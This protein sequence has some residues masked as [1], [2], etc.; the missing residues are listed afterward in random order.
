MHFRLSLESD[1]SV[2]MKIINQAQTQLRDA[3]I[4][5]WQNQY[6]NASSI[7]SDIQL[8]ES[9][10]VLIEDRIVGT[11][12]LSFRIEP[13]YD[14]IYAGSWLSSQAYAVIHRIAIDDQYKGHGLSTKIINEVTIWCTKN[15]IY[16]IKI[17]THADNHIMRNVLVKNGFAYCGIIY[18]RD[19]NQRVAY[20]KLVNQTDAHL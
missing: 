16:S 17:D 10:V 14:T 13:T 15:N 11:F 8:G 4:D 6:P 9:Y 5:Q 12:A 2:I 7:L 19:G 3:G 20:E 1:I 18:L